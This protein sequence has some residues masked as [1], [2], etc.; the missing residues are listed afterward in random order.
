MDFAPAQTTLCVSGSICACISIKPSFAYCFFVVLGK[1][2][3]SGASTRTLAQLGIWNQDM[4]L[5]K[6]FPTSS[7]QTCLLFYS[8]LM[9]SECVIQFDDKLPQFPVDDHHVVRAPEVGFRGSVLLGGGRATSPL[10]R[11]SP[12]PP[13]SATA[14]TTS[15]AS[16]T[17]LTIPSSSSSSNGNGDGTSS[18]GNANSGG[19][20]CNNCTYVNQRSHLACTMCQTP[21]A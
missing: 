4:I 13:P 5:L 6:V 11:A 9:G 18:H 3:P 19:W 21:K 10:P 20:S 14:T 15:A 17:T 12:P 8:L 2:I 1:Q 16:S 7:V